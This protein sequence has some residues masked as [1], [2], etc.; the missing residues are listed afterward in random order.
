[1]C[2]VLAT[3]SESEGSWILGKNR[4]RPYKPTIRIR[5]SFRND[6]ERLFI[7]DE[8]TR[9]TE[10]VNEFGIGIISASVMVKDDEAEGGE[11]EQSGTK[12]RT[13]YSPDGL[14]IRTALLEKTFIDV[15]NK[16]IE[17]EI[18]GNTI[19]ADKDRCVILEGAFEKFEEQENYVYKS[20]EVLK[21]Q[22]VVRTNHGILLDWTG[23]DANNPDQ[24]DARESSNTRYDKVAEKLVNAT[25]IQDILEVLS[26][27][28]DINPQ[29]NPL[30]RDPKRLSMRT[31][32]Q[33]LVVPGNRT[34]YY[35]SVWGNTI[36][37]LNS[38]NK[39]S[40]KCFFE[41]ISGKKILSFKESLSNE[42]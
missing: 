35:R 16:L 4:D 1:M 42:H 38:L 34:L 37:D 30:R 36:F 3:Y 14:R 2:V 6:V 31:T 41:I 11:A 21:N 26:I 40:E 23:Y 7:W 25:N 5:K 19:V 32:G 28:N 8:K 20:K 17:L 18:P 15:L 13:F 9:Y 33:I 39:D 10:G 12:K 27:E 24:A 22:V 29:L